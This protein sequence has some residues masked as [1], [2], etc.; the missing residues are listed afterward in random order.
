MG[1]MEKF[2]T[3]KKPITS[4]KDI[5]RWARKFDPSTY[6]VKES[7]G[8]FLNETF[9]FTRQH[10][11]SMIPWLRIAVFVGTIRFWV[12]K[13]IPKHTRYSLQRFGFF[14]DPL[15]QDH[16]FENLEISTMINSTKQKTL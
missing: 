13:L 15:I 12:I 6:F 3:F 8:G 2:T 14:F 1:K 4:D 11:P 9:T 5:L 10:K 16:A 7:S